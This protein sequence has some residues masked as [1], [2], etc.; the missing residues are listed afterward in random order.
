MFKV[1][2]A[3]NNEYIDFEEF[4]VGAKRLGFPF[5]SKEDAKTA[6]ALVDKSGEQ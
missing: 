3:D 4:Q 2:D 6:F 5:Q 1:L